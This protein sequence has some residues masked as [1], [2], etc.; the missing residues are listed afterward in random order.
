M[1]KKYKNEI[2]PLKL[3]VLGED[4]FDKFRKEFRVDDGRESE[5]RDDVLYGKGAITIKCIEAKSRE[6]GCA[7][8][9][10]ENWDYSLQNILDVVS[11]EAAHVTVHSSVEL[12]LACDEEHSEAFCYLLGY[13]ARCIGNYIDTTM[14]IKV[15]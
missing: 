10:R 7:I 15:R 12:G 1:I 5:I 9:L 8:V 4:D 11:H 3:W 13:Y 2:Y 14:K 6:M